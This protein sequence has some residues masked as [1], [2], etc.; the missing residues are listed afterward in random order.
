ILAN[1]DKY[2]I[3]VANF[4]LH[5]SNSSSFTSDPLDKAVERLWFAGVTVVAAAGN[6]GS[7]S[8]PSGVPYA[9]GNDPIVITVGAADMGGDPSPWNDTAPTWS[10]YGYTNDGFRKPEV[11]ADGR[12]IVGP[13]PMGST[14]AAEKASNIVSPGYIQLSG[15]SF[16]APIVSGIAA[17]ILA[18]HPNWGPDQVKGAL[19]ETAR[20]T[21]K[22]IPGSLGVGEVNAVKAVIA[23]RVANPNKGLE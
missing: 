13:I 19:M 16:S 1:K 15:T 9:P 23:N 22:A 6:Y 7:A 21:P 11:A 18:F 14:L 17:Q 3:K 12:Y 20:P 10:A 4:S 8:G 2:N 5:A